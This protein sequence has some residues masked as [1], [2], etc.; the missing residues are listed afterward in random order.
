MH[1]VC[2]PVLQCKPHAISLQEPPFPDFPFELP[3]A[4]L[5]ASAETINSVEDRFGD[6]IQATDEDL[7][8]TGPFVEFDYSDVS[9]QQK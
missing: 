7:S 9:S 5:L 1:D 4:G 2:A 8:V 6:S 3:S